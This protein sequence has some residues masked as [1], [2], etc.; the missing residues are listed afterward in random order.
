MIV[1][2]IR[3][4]KQGRDQLVTLKRRT[5]IENWNVICRWALCMSLAEPSPPRDQ[6][7]EADSAIEMAWRTFAGENDRVF[8]ALMRQRCREDGIEPTD[9]NAAHQLR[10]HLHRGIS[11]LAGDPKVSGIVPLT[12]K[13]IGA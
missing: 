13:A 9:A 3:V 6:K 4:S 8:E 1:E 7:I 2:S 5:G 11:Y 10:L 12:L